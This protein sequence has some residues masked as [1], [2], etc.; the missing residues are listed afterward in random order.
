MFGLYRYRGIFKAVLFIT[1]LLVVFILFLYVQM[2]IDNLRN[3][4]QLVIQQLANIRAKIPETEIDEFS[5]LFNEFI[6][7]AHFP[8][9][10]TDNNDE[11]AFWT[12]IGIATNDYSPE[13]INKVKNIMRALKEANDPIAISYEGSFVS[14]LY[15]GDSQ[16]IQSL[17]WLP[18]IQIGIIGIFLLVGFYGFNIIRRS[19]ER[20]I[21][22][23]MAKE[24]AHQL[25]TPLTSLMGW[26]ELLKQSSWGRPESITTITEMER[27][28]KRLERVTE[29][30]SQI[31]SQ[32]SMTIQPLAPILQDVAQYIRRRIPQLGPQIT[33]EETY[34]DVTDIPLNRGL[35]EWVVENL[36]KNALDAI[37]AEH[38]K[39]ML[40][41]HGDENNTR[42][43]IDIIDNGK[44]IPAKYHKEIFKPG[45]STKK[46]GWGL[47]L[48]LAKRIVEEYHKGELYIRESDEE[49]EGTTMRIMLKPK[50]LL[51]AKN[52]A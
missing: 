6:Q 1:A 27:D 26:L 38:G 46:R 16:S 44:G 51:K 42:I 28:L 18:Y 11:P 48:S 9:I 33:I 10:L 13:N 43:F 23:G 14:Y 17:S 15:Y 12:G 30:F 24:T 8:M 49:K 2:I 45:F 35:F 20:Y 7:K 40:H 25:G 31:G 32:Q 47:G 37:P 52:T 19:E 41:L 34:E 50:V 4:S 5:F 22:A 36:M 39:V 3:E 29:R 21:Y